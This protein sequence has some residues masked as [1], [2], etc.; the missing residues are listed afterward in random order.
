MTTQDTR[1]FVILDEDNLKTVS[2]KEDDKTFCFETERE[3]DHY[4]A[5]TLN[6]W[7]VIKVH[8]NHRFIHHAPNIKVEL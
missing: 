4:A 7:T 1:V 5:Q 3:A 6:L 2:S 8:F